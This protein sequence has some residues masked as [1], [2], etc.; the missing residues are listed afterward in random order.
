MGIAEFDQAGA[1]GMEGRARFQADGTQGIEATIGV[2]HGGVYLEGRSFRGYL[3]ALTL[4]RP[5]DPWSASITY[6]HQR[7]ILG[8]I[9]RPPYLSAPGRTPTGGLP[10]SGG[11]L[12]SFGRAGRLAHPVP[13]P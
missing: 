7:L 9:H 11:S 8:F 5:M 6:I 13:A 2:A 12:S 4:S 3:A 1:L 10:P